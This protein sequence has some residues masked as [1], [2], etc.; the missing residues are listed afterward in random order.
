MRTFIAFICLS[1]LF[2]SAFAVHVLSPLSTEIEAG[3]QI[4]IGTAGP[5][6]T[7]AVVA[8][9][10]VTTGGKFGT[11]GAYD[12]MFASS[13]PDGWASTPS[14]LYGKTL[15]ADITI[16]KDAPDGVYDI[17]LSLWDEAGSAGLGD[18]VA[19]TV[20]VNV[21]R[22]VMDMKIEPASLSVGAGQPARYA[23]TVNNK[24]IANDVF[25]VGSSGVRDWEFKR[26]MY[27]PSGTSK[28]INYEVVGNDE[29]DYRVAIYARSSSSDRIYSES[30]VS[31]TVN[32]NLLS[33]FRA[34]TRGVLLFPLIEAPAYFIAGL[35]SNFFQ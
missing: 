9:P 6:Q 25:E 28:T 13:L 23:I 24:G 17:M 30:P 2:S 14:K 10:V 29:A 8:D 22:D 3:S 18:D 15:Q 16:P 7:F 21:A 34:T 12:K 32:T 1:A 5:G 35:I 20:K 11:G 27:I 4:S 33:D 31:L 19:F 26:S